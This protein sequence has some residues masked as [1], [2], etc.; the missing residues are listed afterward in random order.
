[1]GNREEDILSLFV[2]LGFFSFSF[3]KVVSHRACVVLS[4]VCCH[5]PWLSF[6]VFFVPFFLALLSISFF[7]RVLSLVKERIASF[8]FPGHAAGRRRLHAASRR[9]KHTESTD[10]ERWPYR[11]THCDISSFISLIPSFP[12]LCGGTPCCRPLYLV[13]HHLQVH[14]HGSGSLTVCRQVGEES[15][16]TRKSVLVS[17]DIL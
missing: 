11:E 13:G 14:R 5:R 1:M 12:L 7:L 10:N 8:S 4:P 17:S 6:S 3:D 16:L 15:A 2:C 9:E